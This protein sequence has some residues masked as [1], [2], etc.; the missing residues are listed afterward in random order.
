[1]RSDDLERR[2]SAAEAMLIVDRKTTVDE[3]LFLLDS[4]EA[5][6]R[7][8]VSGLLMDYGK[9]NVNAQNKLIQVATSDK[10]GNVRAMACET[11]AWIGDERCIEPL[12]KVA[13]NDPGV[14]FQGTPVKVFAQQAIDEIIDRLSGHI[15]GND[16]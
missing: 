13:A 7:R 10:D 14:D 12:R 8:H 1:M 4:P 11:L 15:I 9:G 5:W 2:T 6:I 16:K 3:I